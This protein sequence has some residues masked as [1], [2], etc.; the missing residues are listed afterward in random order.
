VAHQTVSGA[1]SRAALKPATLGF[2]Q[3]VLRYNS[4][5]CPVRRRS[6]GNLVPMVNC[7]SESARQRSEVR[8]EKSEHTGYARCGTGLSGAATGQRVS[9][10]DRSKLQRACWRGT[11]RTVN[12]TCSVHHQ[13]TWCAHRQQKQPTTRKWLEAINT[14]NHLLQWH[15]SFLKFTFNT[16]AITFTPRHIPKIKSSPS[17]QINSIH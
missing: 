5:D 16:R 11:H 2:F 12:S 1:L 15:P 6:N 4:P 9:T 17:L 13:T 14:P 8:A 3:G 10:V 7:Q